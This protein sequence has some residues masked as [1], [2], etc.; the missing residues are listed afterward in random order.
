MSPPPSTPTP[1]RFL[2]SKRSTQT[3]QTPAQFPQFQSTPRFGSSSVPRPTQRRGHDIEVVDEEDDESQDSLPEDE[4]VG[5]DARGQYD[6][7]EVE[8][9]ALSASQH[10]EESSRGR[11]SDMDL[12]DDIAANSLQVDHVHRVEWSPEGR[13]A[14]RRKVSIS[15]VPD[16]EPPTGQH[17]DADPIPGDE[18]L[19]REE[20]ED[21]GSVND[22]DRAA[23]QPVFQ[24]A[25]RFKPVEMDQAMEGL[26][27]AFSP[28]R[29]G[30]KYLADGLAAGLQGWLSEVKGWKGIDGAADSTLGITIEEVRPGRQ[31]YLARSRAGADGASRRFILAGEGKLTGLGRRAAVAVGSAVTIGQPVWD[32]ELDGEMWT[33]ACDWSVA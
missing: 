20:S 13:D 32:V 21:M 1:R 18:N 28:Q 30:A 6:S 24:P 22:A 17:G 26:P 25:P 16:S 5:D 15:P 19:Q 29:R 9:D 27:A 31:M 10:D 3:A 4:A 8:S 2:L 33:V 12:R 14:K 23:Q 7:I 11:D